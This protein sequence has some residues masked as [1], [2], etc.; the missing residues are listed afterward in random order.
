L[1]R[2]E[3]RAGSQ[4]AMAGV[5]RSRPGP[6]AELSGKAMELSNAILERNVDGHKLH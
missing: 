1:T 2:R 4:A 5:Y 3:V 6:S